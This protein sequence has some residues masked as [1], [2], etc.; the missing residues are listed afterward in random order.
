MCNQLRAKPLTRAV[1]SLVIS[2]PS[3]EPDTAS[4]DPEAVR[5]ELA[6]RDDDCSR[7]AEE[8]GGELKGRFRD[9]SMPSAVAS[10]AEE[11]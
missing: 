6:T 5:S 9:N 10:K 2:I 4:V 3:W 7:R 11:D 1:K 8:D